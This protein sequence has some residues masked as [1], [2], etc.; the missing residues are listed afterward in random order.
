[1]GYTVVGLQLLGKR[2]VYPNKYN[3]RK[4]LLY[5]NYYNL[6][7]TIVGARTAVAVASAPSYHT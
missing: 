2:R 4:S 7:W 6:E 1:M 5:S 3:N